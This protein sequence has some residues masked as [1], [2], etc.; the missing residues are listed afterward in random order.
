MRPAPG[1]IVFDVLA[2]AY[3]FHDY[4]NFLFYLMNLVGPHPIHVLMSVCFPKHAKNSQPISEIDIDWD[5]ASFKRRFMCSL[6]VGIFIRL[7]QL[8]IEFDKKGLRESFK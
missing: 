2:Y 6:H 4:Q 3:K 5:F 7:K 8:W 1:P